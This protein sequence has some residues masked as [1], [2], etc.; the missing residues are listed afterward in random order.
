MF[1][2]QQPLGK[3]VRQTGGKIIKPTEI[4][5]L[6]RLTQVMVSLNKNYDFN[7]L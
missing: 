1:P 4:Y 2:L 6:I 3:A 7:L 5:R